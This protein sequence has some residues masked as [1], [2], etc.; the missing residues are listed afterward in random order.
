MNRDEK[1]LEGLGCQMLS[2]QASPGSEG[3]PSVFLA[4]QVRGDSSGLVLWYEEGGRILIH[5][6]QYNFS[7]LSNTCLLVKSHLQQKEKCFDS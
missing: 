3:L 2:P 5:L 4:C 7:P 6:F 1:T